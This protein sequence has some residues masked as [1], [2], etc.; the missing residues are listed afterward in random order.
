MCVIKIGRRK[1]V[2][3]FVQRVMVLNQQ[4]LPSLLV[5][6]DLQAFIDPTIVLAMFMLSFIFVIVTINGSMWSF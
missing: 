4:I 6:S 3:V 5:V 2:I 1:L